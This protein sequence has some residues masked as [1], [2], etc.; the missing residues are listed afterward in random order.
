MKFVAEGGEGWIPV[1]KGEDKRLDKE[2]GIPTGDE[3]EG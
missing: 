2:T 1:V 3:S